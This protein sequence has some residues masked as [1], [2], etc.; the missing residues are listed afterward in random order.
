M[1]SAPAPAQ[2]SASVS[3]P[4]CSGKQIWRGGRGGERGRER[5]KAWVFQ[6]CR[7]KVPVKISWIFFLKIVIGPLTT[8]IEFDLNY[9]SLRNSYRIFKEI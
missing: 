7:K 5:E 6:R 8:I 1:A 2:A 9:F 3:P 4:L